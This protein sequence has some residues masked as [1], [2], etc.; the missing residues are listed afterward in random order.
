MCVCVCVRE[1]ERERVC[2][3]GGVPAVREDTGRGV[4]QVKT[5]LFAGKI[6]GS[7]FVRMGS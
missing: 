1:R 4:V 7:G 6:F 3:C 5:C 2:L